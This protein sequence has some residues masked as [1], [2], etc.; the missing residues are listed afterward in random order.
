MDVVEDILAIY[1]TYGFDTEV[2]VASIRN[3]LH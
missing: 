2:I 3:P 1:D